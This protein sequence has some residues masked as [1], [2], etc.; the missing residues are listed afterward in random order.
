MFAAQ[1]A[2]A[3]GGQLPDGR[4]PATTRD[5]L[6]AAASDLLAEGGTG[7]V[8]LRGVGERA[9]V[10]RTAPYRHFRDKDDLLAAVAAAAFQQLYQDMA[11]AVAAAPSPV[12][13]ALRRACR[14]YVR[15]GLSWPEHYRLIF[16]E[17]LVEE[18]HSELTKSIPEG[19][20]Y[21]VALLTRGQ[22]AEEVR[23]GDA[24]D[25]TILT[26]S[27]LHGLVTLAQSGHLVR[28]GIESEE[29]LARLLDE[30]VAGLEV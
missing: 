8:T 2:H 14:A 25:L 6:V 19:I 13:E 18:E 4:L 12:P 28:K 24:Q 16:H 23:S 9:G 5:R 20:Q 26:W 1:R 11:T 17:R 27:A 10:S 22:Q 21:F 7:A 29:A 30:L 3:P 15:F